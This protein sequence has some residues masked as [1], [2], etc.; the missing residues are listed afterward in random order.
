MLLLDNFEHV[1]AAE[2]LVTDILRAAPGFT[3]LVT[4]RVRLCVSG[5]HL[6]PVPPLALPDPN[7]A[8][9][10]ATANQTKAVQRFVARSCRRSW[11]ETAPGLEEVAPMRDD[12][13]SVYT[14]DAELR[15]GWERELRECIRPVPHRADDGACYIRIDLWSGQRSQWCDPAGRP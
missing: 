13:H 9:T 2:P 11:A 6:F 10:A 3:V 15:L 7:R 5:E 14:N 12:A 1:V 4:S 8:A